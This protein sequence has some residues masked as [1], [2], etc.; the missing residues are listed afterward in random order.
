MGAQAPGSL[1]SA[2]SPLTCGSPLPWQGFIPQDHLPASL[3]SLFWMSSDGILL[4][5]ILALLNTF[6]LPE[7][8][9]INLFGSESTACS[10]SLV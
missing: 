10:V 2:L 9:P 6:P 7:L 1:F 5:F 8:V 3:S 4:G